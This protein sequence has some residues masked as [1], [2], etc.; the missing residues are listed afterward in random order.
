VSTSIHSVV[1]IILGGYRG[2]FLV[3]IVIDKAELCRPG[4][5]CIFEI[6]FEHILM[7]IRNK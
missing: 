7:E 2:L 3:A 1:L 6:K 5:C 4:A